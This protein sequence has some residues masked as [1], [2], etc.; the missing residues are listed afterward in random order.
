MFY[1]RFGCGWVLENTRSK[2]HGLIH[3]RSIKIVHSGYSVHERHII[4]IIILLLYYCI[5]IYIYIYII[6]LY[7]GKR[8]NERVPCTLRRYY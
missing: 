7:E 4:I 8:V 2:R 5:I 6:L 3:F 1:C